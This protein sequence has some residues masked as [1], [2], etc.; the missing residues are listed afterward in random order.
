MRLPSDVLDR[1]RG[2]LVVAALTSCGHEDV[3]P[4]APLTTSVAP[5][6][7]APSQP[8]GEGPRQ[9]TGL[10]DPVGYASAD[11]ASRL[12]RLDAEDA[13]TL[14]SRRARL[15]RLAQ[16]QEPEALGV[17]QVLGVGAP[18]GSLQSAIGSL[19]SIGPGPG[20]GIHGCAG[21]GRG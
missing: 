1:V 14:A 7:A 11:E 10:A 13:A 19:G 17:A 15:K 3:K 4:P 20:I 9:T 6:V 12:A 16:Q 21:C 8:A 18:P 5:D 2:A